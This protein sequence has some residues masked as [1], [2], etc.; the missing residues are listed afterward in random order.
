MLSHA[1]VRDFWSI[2]DGHKKI[3]SAPA[4]ATRVP[5]TLQARQGLALCDPD[6]S[7]IFGAV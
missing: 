5:C 3:S 2:I 7:R 6:R 1:A 4:R